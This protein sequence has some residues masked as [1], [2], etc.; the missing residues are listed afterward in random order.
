MGYLWNAE[1][2]RWFW[3]PAHGEP[4]PDESEAP[5]EAQAA[6]QAPPRTPPLRGGYAPRVGYATTTKVRRPADRPIKREEL[7]PD[8]SPC[9]DPVVTRLI[10]DLQLATRT[11]R[12]VARGERP[13]SQWE[14]ADEF[15]KGALQHL[16]NYLDAKAWVRSS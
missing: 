3:N 2:K 7:I 12:K 1:A 11:M 6:R 16:C 15:A 13:A 4:P 14:E 9:D 8:N 10:L 5:W